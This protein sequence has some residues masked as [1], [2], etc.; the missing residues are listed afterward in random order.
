MHRVSHNKGNNEIVTFIMGH[1]V[2]Q[3]LNGTLY[4]TY[5]QSSSSP[6]EYEEVPFS[7]KKNKCGKYSQDSTF[8]RVLKEQVLH[9]S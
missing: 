2:P 5:F 7:G 4:I 9:V 6:T 3:N 1:P 8:S